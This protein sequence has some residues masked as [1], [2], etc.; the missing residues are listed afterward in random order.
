MQIVADAQHR[1]PAIQGLADFISSYFVPS[2]IGLAL[3]TWAFWTVVLHGGLLPASTIPAAALVHPSLT[4]FTFG[5]AV[6]VVAC[7]CALGLATPAAVMV[8][9]GVSAAHG[10]L[11]KGG[12]VLERAGSLGVVLFDKTGTLTSGMLQVKHVLSWAEGVPAEQVVRLAA[13]AER[14]SKHPIA[15]AIGRHAQAAGVPTVEP[16]EAATTAGLG[17]RCRVD[18]VGVVLGNAVMLAGRGTEAT[19][20]QAA[21]LAALEQEGHTVV[22]L[23]RE[24]D[25]GGPPVLVGVLALA[26]TLRPESRAVVELLH[27]WRLEVWMVSGDNERAA[28]AF[29]AAAAIPP[30]RVVAGVQPAGKLDVVKRL[31][32]GKRAVAFVGDGINDAPALA[33][34][35]VGIAVGSGTDVAIETADVVLMKDSLADVPIAIDLA[36]VVMARIR[37]NFGWAFGGRP[38]PRARVTRARRSRRSRPQRRGAVPSVPPG[39]HAV[40]PSLALCAQ[41]TI[42]SVCPSRPAS[43]T[44]RLASS[45]RQ[46]LRA[47]QWRSLRSRSSARRCSSA[48]T[49]RRACSLRRRTGRSMRPS[50][51]CEALDSES[52]PSLGVYCIR[53]RKHPPHQSTR[54][55]PA[56]WMRLPG[57]GIATDGAGRDRRHRCGA[58]GSVRPL[59]CAARCEAVPRRRRSVST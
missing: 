10:I 12:D 21:T 47:R 3:A 54:A 6:L 35:E 48:S 26:D 20:P 8:G 15:V 38:P 50:R 46:C 16:T 49:G 1:K 53:H 42:C 57:I 36:R 34:A 28:H 40:N 45:C 17:L 11:F 43:C 23:G 19:P 4:A 51:C 55:V 59:A 2:I 7:P 52:G 29:A 31:Q 27:R 44:H 25:D 33:Q 39:A 5:C 56:L 22:L 32:T 30:N 13:S 37:L 18:G 41:A 9:S 24:P 14:G 58:R